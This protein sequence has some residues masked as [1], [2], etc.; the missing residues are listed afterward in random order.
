MHYFFGLLGILVSAFMLKYRERVGDFV[1]EADW[2]NKLGGV[3][4][5]IIIFSIFLFLW[6]VAT[7][8]DTTQFLFAPLRWLIPG[9]A[10][11]PPPPVPQGF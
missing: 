3:Y 10:P 7:L 4:N 9:L 6:S 5:V 8:T 11:P 2:M 1:G